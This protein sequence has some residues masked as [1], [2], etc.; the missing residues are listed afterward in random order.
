[1]EK[2]LESLSYNVS[3]GQMIEHSQSALTK[4][5]S[6]EFP[7]KNILTKASRKKKGKP[8]ASFKV[9]MNNDEPSSQENISTKSKKNQR[10][11]KEIA[12]VS[13]SSSK[14]VNN[15]ITLKSEEIQN[16]PS[17]TWVIQQ[18]R[19]LAPDLEEIGGLVL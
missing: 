10:K 2:E 19:K 15:R 6:D 17:A 18:L 7:D 11:S 3:A 9:G 13:V 16:I 4:A 14:M 1:M 5:D 8:S 12:T